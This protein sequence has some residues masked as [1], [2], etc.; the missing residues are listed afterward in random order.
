[1]YLGERK[2]KRSNQMQLNRFSIDVFHRLWRIKVM[3]GYIR[4]SFNGCMN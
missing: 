1:M 3:N 4:I 2:R